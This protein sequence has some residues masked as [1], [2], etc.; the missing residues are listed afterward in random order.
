MS[1]I[2]NLLLAAA[3]GV[4][5]E[6]VRSP[7]TVYVGPAAPMPLDHLVARRNRALEVLPQFDRKIAR[8]IK[9]YGSANEL[10]AKKAEIE[11]QLKWLEEQIQDRLDTRG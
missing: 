5:V 11:Q 1:M 4:P 7:A 3:R 10:I 6:A 8:S 9:V 2:R